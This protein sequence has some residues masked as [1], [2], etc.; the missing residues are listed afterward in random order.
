LFISRAN[1]QEKVDF[2][3]ALHQID[4]SIDSL[5]QGYEEQEP[6]ISI[7]IVSNNKLVY[8]KQFG[9]ANLEY[10]IPINDK[11]SFHVA[12]VSK[13]FTAFAILL[14]ED[15]GKLSL[16]DDIRVFLPEMHDFQNTITIRHLL[17]HTSGLKD[18]YNLLRLSGWTL[19]DVITN[20]QILRILFNQ[21]TL[22]FQPN[23]KHMYSNSGYTLLAEIVARVSGMSFA[24]FTNKHIFGP[25]QMHQSNIKNC[26]K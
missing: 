18:Q 26:I 15:E 2:A 23:E 11:T 22:N 9:L 12:S 10:Q 4:K 14:L 21:R 8:E 17:N 7:G 1:A 13:Q 25:L 24:E 19:D 3:L 16:D 5:L 6:G 20:E